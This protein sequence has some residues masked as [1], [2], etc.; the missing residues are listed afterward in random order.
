MK[1]VYWL[2]PD[3]RE[4]YVCEGS[5]STFQ[6]LVQYFQVIFPLHLE[7]TC[8][9]L[10]VEAAREVVEFVQTSINDNKTTY[11]TVSILILSNGMTFFTSI[12]QLLKAAGFFNSF[13]TEAVIT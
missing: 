5:D 11:F 1:A 12:T 4:I 2:L 9:K 8:S 6:Y 7:F 3:R 10:T 13:M